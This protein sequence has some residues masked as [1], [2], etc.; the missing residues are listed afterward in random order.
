MTNITI[1]KVDYNNPKQVDTLIDLLDEYAR[2]PMGGAEPLA[3]EVKIRLAAD[4]HKQ[5]NMFSL[6]VSVDDKAA[7]F[8]NCVWGYSTFAAKPLVNIHDLAV[9][10]GY[11]GLGLSQKL[12]DAVAEEVKAV[13]GVKITLEVLADNVVAQNAY[14][15]YGFAPYELPGDAGCA[16]FWQ[17]YIK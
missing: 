10:A 4:L 15:R 11:R 16:Q 17:Y 13:D 12:L 7:G 9:M 2:D 1:T 5:S 14:R 6:I 3:D 8:C